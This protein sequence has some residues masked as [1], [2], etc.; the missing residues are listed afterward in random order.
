MSK[1]VTRVRFKEKFTFNKIRTKASKIFAESCVESC[2]IQVIIQIKNRSK[3]ERLAGVHE[4][5]ILGVF[6]VTLTENS[7]V[8]TA[9]M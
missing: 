9:E 7:S 6:F 3:T 8:V 1:N 5:P 2:L 4:T